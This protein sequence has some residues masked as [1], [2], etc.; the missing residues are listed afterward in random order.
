MKSKSP[1]LFLAALSILLMTAC[2]AFSQP[3]PARTDLCQGSYY[4]EEQA[5]QVLHDLAA[6]YRDRPSCG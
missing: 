5:A 6:Q 2:Q 1:V 4:T 3:D